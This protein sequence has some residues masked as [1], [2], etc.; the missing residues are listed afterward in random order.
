MIDGAAFQGEVKS[1][2][3][4]AVPSVFVNGELFGQGR[5]SLAEI[6]NKVDSGAAEK[7][8]ASLMSKHL[9]TYWLWAVAQQVHQLPSMPLVKVF[10]LV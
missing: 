4:M 8:A 6:L 5:M 9:S 2:D 10:A 1:R 7:K 3:I